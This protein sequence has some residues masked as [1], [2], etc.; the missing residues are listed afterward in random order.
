M[1]TL[2][3][4]IVESSMVTEKKKLSTNDTPEKKARRAKLVKA[5]IDSQYVDYIGNLDNILKEM[6]K[7]DKLRNLLINGFGGENGDVNFDCESVDINV[8]NLIPTQ[9]EIDI[10]KSLAFPLTN[11]KFGKPE[12]YFK[13]PVVLGK[14]PLPIVTFNNS[15]II[16]GHHRWSQIYA[17]NPKAIVKCINYSV[18][19]EEF[20]V[21]QML[22][23][24]Q[25]AIAAT[26]A[27]PTN[28]NN[29]DNGQLPK[30]TADESTNIYKMSEA[31]I[32]KYIKDN[33]KDFVVEEL[34]KFVKSLK[35]QPSSKNPE[36]EAKEKCIEYIL[37]NIMTL[38]TPDKAPYPNNAEKKGPSTKESSAP[39]RI[40][41]PQ[42]DN[43]GTDGDAQTDANHKSSGVEHEGSA[44]YRLDK[45]T[46]DGKLTGRA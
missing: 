22:K 12:Q 13:E 15:F 10:T 14:V 30:A 6:E 40:F 43:G 39:S 4:Y 25:G 2:N 20:S 31:K 27:D 26:I 32:K 28:D 45:G 18:L 41:M 33:I 9:S 37:K 16:D 8:G 38:K 5:L 1:K 46:V 24:T 11:E 19:K 17:M 21:I 29:G 34:P 42:T 44:L 3:E 7:D 36:K 23:A 35:P